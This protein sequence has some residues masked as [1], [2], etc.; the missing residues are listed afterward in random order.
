M[1]ER[2]IADR[3]RWGSFWKSFVTSPQ[4]FQGLAGKEVFFPYSQ[5]LILPMRPE[6]FLALLECCS[7]VSATVFQG[8]QLMAITAASTQILLHSVPD[9]LQLCRIQRS[10][11]LSVL[12]LA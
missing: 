4:I 6:V 8:T 12:Y 2:V 5:P 10:P 11:D 3:N 1:H 9:S 7:M